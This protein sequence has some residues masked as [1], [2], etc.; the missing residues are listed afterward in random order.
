MDKFIFPSFHS[1]LGRYRCTADK[2]K[3]SSYSQI[4]IF[5]EFKQKT[6]KKSDSKRAQTEKSE[7]ERSILEVRQGQVDPIELSVEKPSL[8]AHSLSLTFTST[9]S[10]PPK[11]LPTSIS[12]SVMPVLVTPS[13]TDLPTFPPVLLPSKLPSSTPSKLPSPPPLLIPV[14][15]S[16]PESQPQP[17]ILKLN[18]D[19]F[20]ELFEWLA[21]ADLLRLRQTCKKFKKIVDFFIREYYPAIKFGYAKLCLPSNNLD[22]FGNFDS[23]STKMI[24]K[25]TFT[26]CLRNEQIKN[27]KPILSN[28][29]TIEISS[30]GIEGNFYEQFLKFCPN[31]KHLCIWN[32]CGNHVIGSGNEWMLHHYPK[33]QHI[34]LDDSDIDGAVYGCEIVELKTFF[35]LNPNIRVLNTSVNFLWENRNW[36]KGA[37]ISLDLLNLYG[38]C[39]EMNPY[40]ELFL[41]L[42][43]ELFTQGFFKR[44]HF[45]ESIKFAQQIS[46]SSFPIEILHL[47]I[48]ESNESIVLPPLKM[49]KELSF[50]MGSDALKA[51]ENNFN[52]IDRICMVYAEFVDILPFIRFSRRIKQIGVCHFRQTDDIYFK[53][54]IIDVIALNKERKKLKGAGKITIYVEEKL[55]LATKWA[56]G[57]SVDSLVQLKRSIARERKHCF[58]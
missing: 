54:G 34:E 42:L 39:P 19:C 20:E 57:I 43:N 4:E 51:L 24:K 18:I 41:G 46:E 6:S 15:P 28:I 45:F 8:S 52:N 53:D 21:L 17:K 16:P 9:Q 48:P 12:H 44:L 50:R 36:L 58:Y 26:D 35:E 29:E 11:N 7:M 56:I 25:I 37:N 33:L 5:C 22:K 40:M 14:L 23:I 1:N 31:L 10:A 30:Y 2:F 32:I 55:F 38:N 3:L 49:I 47:E 13:S 27:L